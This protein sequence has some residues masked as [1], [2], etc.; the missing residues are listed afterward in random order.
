MFARIFPLAGLAAVVLAVCASQ[1]AAAP[2][3]NGCQ[4]DPK[5]VGPIELSTADAPG[6][7]WRL[8]KDGLDAAGVTDYKTT[9]EGWF[10]TTFAS[11]N[12]AIETLVGAVRSIDRNGDGYVCASRIRG[13]RAHFDDPTIAF[14]LFSVIDN[15]RVT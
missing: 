9:M 11:L 6:T 7:W 13:T 4:S 2:A 14:T 12:D 5:L 15:K 10:G 3:A 1:A 8:T